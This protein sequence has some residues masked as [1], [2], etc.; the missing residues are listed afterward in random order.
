MG[1]TLQDRAIK[2]WGLSKCCSN[3]ML[4]VPRIEWLVLCNYKM[5]VKSLK[6]V[7]P[8]V[9]NMLSEATHNNTTVTLC[10]ISQRKENNACTTQ[11]KNT[12]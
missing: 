11:S 6:G 3:K 5:T 7:W 12:T 1:I 4:K 9:Q 8:E 2:R 10:Q